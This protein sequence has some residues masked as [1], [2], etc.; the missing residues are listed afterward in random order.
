MNK[1]LLFLGSCFLFG[2]Y[3]AFFNHRL[4][5]GIYGTSIKGENLEM[6]TGGVSLIFGMICILG[7]LHEKR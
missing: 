1:G 5:V 3:D 2:A 6:L 7:A 4:F